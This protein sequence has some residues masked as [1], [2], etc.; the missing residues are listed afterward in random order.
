MNCLIHDFAGHSF[1]IQLSRELAGRGHHVTH[2]YPTGLQ[3][4]KGR[5]EAADTD[6][7]RLEILGVPLQRS[8]RKYSPWR[9]LAAQ[10]RYALDLRHIV[11][12]R[13]F[14]VMLSGNTPVDVQ[15]DL[16]GHCRDVTESALFIGS[17]MFTLRL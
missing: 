3:G 14:D 11:A 17:R 9:R 15:F 5:L 8:F 13:R 16:L 7:P 10:R 4:P 1:Q 12:S 6:S 2:V